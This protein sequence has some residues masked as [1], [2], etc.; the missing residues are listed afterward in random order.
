MIF[1][2]IYYLNYF[3]LS[4]FDADTKRA[5][6]PDTTGRHQTVFSKF[7]HMVFIFWCKSDNELLDGGVF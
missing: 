7:A 2:L 1:Y 6:Y 4:Y 5:V 3:Y